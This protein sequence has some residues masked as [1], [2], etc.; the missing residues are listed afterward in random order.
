M[1][2]RIQ[3]LIVVQRMDEICMPKHTH[4][5]VRNACMLVSCMCMH[6]SSIKSWLLSI[7]YLIYIKHSR[8][9]IN[10]L[11]RDGAFRDIAAR[12]FLS[13]VP[14]FLC[15]FQMPSSVSSYHMLLVSMSYKLTMHLG[16]LLDEWEG[17]FKLQKFLQT[18]NVLC[19]F[20]LE[21]IKR[22]DGQK[23]HPGEVTCPLLLY[24]LLGKE[25]SVSVTL[26]FRKRFFSI[27]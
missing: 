27:A 6:S 18:T 20:T 2:I 23:V 12:G 17:A 15:V 11:A 10:V 9:G 7:Y 5:Y 25:I 4:M 19:K 13:L 26:N 1:T 16:F 22:R 24:L 8:Y 3:L 21:D 14:L